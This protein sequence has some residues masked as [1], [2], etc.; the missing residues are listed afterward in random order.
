MSDTDRI[1]E[2]R[3]RLEAATPGEWYK[4]DGVFDTLIGGNDHYIV[5]ALGIGSSAQ[6]RKDA[7]F[8]VH[9][10]NDD[11]RYLLDQLAQL[12][13][14]NA[15]LVDAYVKDETILP[16]GE[17]GASVPDLVQRA[18]KAEAELARLQAKFADEMKWVE[19]YE[20]RRA[21][22]LTPI[23]AIVR[24]VFKTALERKEFQSCPQQLINGSGTMVE[25]FK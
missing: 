5:S 6:D 23:M 21:N 3:A 4:Q 13:A 10:H 12:R 22:P 19:F 7:E 9:A 1:A 25:D 16:N 11:M 8:I 17:V 18:E 24:D 15:R 14:E 20:T 2:I